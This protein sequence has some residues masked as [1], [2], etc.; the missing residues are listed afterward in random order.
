[1]RKADYGIDAP[2]TQRN[3]LIL[4]VICCALLAIP[5]VGAYTIW[6][7]VAFILTVV[8]MYW[9]SKSGK[10]KLRDKLLN[11]IPWK[12]DE[13]VLDVGC[14]R[15]LLLI[16]AA[17]R[18]PQGHGVGIDLWR[19]VDLANNSADKAMDN[20]R[21]ERVADHVKFREGDARELPCANESFDVVLSSWAI[22][23]ITVSTGR[24]KAI[25]EMVRVLKPGGRIGILDIEDTAQYVEELRKLGMQSIKRGSPSFIFLLPTYMV[26][27]VKPGVAEAA[28]AA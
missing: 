27:A 3:L 14:G 7:G 10:M 20:A 25:S 22:H 19:N 17:K 18:A 23:N 12:G 6:P 9:G 16:G 21:I 4:G 24:A 13:E 11:A 8:L 15:G 2:I 26:T 5:K 28:T 1:M